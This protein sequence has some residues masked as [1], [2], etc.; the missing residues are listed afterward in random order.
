MLERLVVRPELAAYESALRACIDDLTAFEDE[1]FAIPRGVERDP[2]TGELAVVSEFVPGS[3]LSELLETAYQEGA[4]P[5]LDVALGFLTEA[6]PT[7][8]ALH[9][10]AGITHGIIAPSRIVLPSPGKIVFLD[11][12]F[13]AML[14]RLE[15]TRLRLWTEFEVAMPE[16]TG[17]PR[18]D[19]T[20]DLGQLALTALMLVLG[21]P[22]RAD[23]YPHALPGLLMEIVEVA[24]I[25]GSGELAGSVQRFLQRSLPLPGRRPYASADEAAAEIAQIVRRDI[26]MPVCRRAFADFLHQMELAAGTCSAEDSGW[27]EEPVL[28]ARSPVDESAGPEAEAFE[29]ELD[30]ESFG[31]EPSAAREYPDIYEIADVDGPLLAEFADDPEESVTAPL[32][33]E[34]VAD[35]AAI[36]AV[37]DLDQVGAASVIEEAAAPSAVEEDETPQQ[38][39]QSAGQSR[40]R[41]RRRSARARKDNLRSA[42]DGTKQ[43]PVS[44]TVAKPVE[45]PTPP[46]SWLIPPGKAAAFEPAVV[47]TMPPVVAAP[48]PPVFA[49]PPPVAYVPPPPRPVPRPA[50]EGAPY[51]AAT[52]GW[53]PPAVTQMPV[54]A[55]AV[56][57]S[58][59]TAQPG[60]IGLKL[61]T[62]PPVGYAPSRGGHSQS[63]RDDFG[64]QP[65][66]R[67]GA[68]RESSSRWK[69]AAAAVVVLLVG[70]VA[71]RQYLPGRNTAMPVLTGAATAPPPT[72]PARP[73]PTAG[74]VGLLDIVT[75]PAGVRVLLDGKAVGESPLKLE[76]V[77][78]GR[79]VLTFVS[80]SGTVKRTVRVE[81]GK[82]VSVDVPVF[83]GWVGVF[84]PI[85]LEVSEN[86]RQV[87]TTEESRLM[88]AP[89]R[90][91]L[92]LTNRDLGYVSTHTVDIEPGEVFS[93]TLSPKGT[94]SFNASPWAEVWIDGNKAGETPIANLEVTL[95]VHE[96]VFK[97]PAHG[98]RRVTAT[99]RADVP[100]AV[101]MDFSK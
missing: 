96:I 63:R 64:G 20:V 23:E 82:T 61:K 58:A 30:L 71:G 76:A 12:A 6:L 69:Y 53:A 65:F 15:F 39:H 62:A 88:L 94:A 8:S 46:T 66:E 3:R 72:T 93:L 33:S 52:A 101:S 56:P 37:E 45:V 74:A 21:R 49:P 28:Q 60:S 48:A 1:R 80:T 18:F 29:E 36:E 100:T 68:E 34:A 75:Q 87:G 19:S 42:A 16:S 50:H 40:R 38:D 10:S 26:G 2:A 22:L 77:P 54:A 41:K 35:A 9:S 11:C 51:A 44:A 73:T 92:T 91:I 25:R 59:P 55:P 67:R 31:Q 32:E 5:G 70:G 7:L 13:A 86:G 84:A 57:P 27:A 14:E 98:E 83:S 99:I 79:H 47:E 85:V 17:R 95:G 24:Q 89:G 43:A 4:V 97:H 78:A 90:H 81:G